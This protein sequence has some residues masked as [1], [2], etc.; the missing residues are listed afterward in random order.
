MAL[1]WGAP[2]SSAARRGGRSALDAGRIVAAAVALAD[3]EGLSAV[4]MRRV[5][6]EVGVPTMTLYGHLPGKG[7]LVDLMLD[8]VL[9]E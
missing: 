1:L 3:A 2:G 7:E 6:A 8:A 9:G 5:A 4:S